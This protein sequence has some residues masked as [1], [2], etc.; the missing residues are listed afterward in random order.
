M[1][2]SVEWILMSEIISC[3]K[4]SDAFFVSGN[5]PLRRESAWSHRKEKMSNFMKKFLTNPIGQHTLINICINM[6][7]INTAMVLINMF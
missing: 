1:A 7:F 3:K 5:H 6:I 4:F 2:Q